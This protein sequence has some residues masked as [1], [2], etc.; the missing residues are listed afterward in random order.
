MGLRRTGLFEAPSN[1]TNVQR[2]ESPIGDT[3]S[4]W[5]ALRQ[6]A[7]AASRALQPLQNQQA[8][9]QAQRDY[10][11]GRVGLRLQLNAEDEVY[12]NAMTQ[13]YLLGAERDVDQRALQLE[14]EYADDADGFTKAFEAARS[15]FMESVPNDLAPHL[16]QLLDT[17][18]NEAVSRIGERRRNAAVASFAAN[19]AA[20]LTQQEMRLT[21]YDDPTSQEFQDAFSAYEETGAAIIANPL[22]GITSEEW[23]L[24]RDNFM[25]RVTA[26]S[27]GLTAERMYEEGGANASAAA[28]AMSFIEGRMRDPELVL[29]EAQRDASFNEARRR[30]MRLETD[31]RRAESEGRTQMRLMR[32]DATIAA[33]DYMSGAQAMAQSF[34]VI[35]PDQI[36]AIGTVVAA[37]GNPTLARE[38]NELQITNHVRSRL[39]GLSLSQ[40]DAE[41]V[42]IRERAQNGD[43]DAAFELRAAS[44]YRQ[45][46]TRADPLTIGQIHFGEEPASIV[47]AD[48]GLSMSARIRDAESIAS[49]LGRSD[50]TYFAPGEAEQL[51]AMV[52]GGGDNAVY[53]AR[54]IVSDSMA[55]GGNGIV[56]AHRM[57]A[58]IA[59]RNSPEFAAIGQVY[60]NGGEVSSNTTLMMGRALEAR[61]QEGYRRAALRPQGVAEGLEAQILNDVLGEQNVRTMSA[62]QRAQIRL[63]ADLFYEG[64][65][66][67]DPSAYDTTRNYEAA[68]RGA[69]SAVLGGV[70]RTIGDAQRPF[71]GVASMDTDASFV[72]PRMRQTYNVENQVIIPNWMR[73]DQFATIYQSLS[74]ADF[75]AAGGG[76]PSGGSLAEWREARLVPTG[77]ALGE[78]FLMDSA[79]ATYAIG[80]GSTRRPY[81]FNLNALRERLAERRPDAAVR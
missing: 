12:N 38:Y 59:G 33:R 78:Y 39:N 2:I 73:R 32:A 81:V 48:G 53:V 60:L 49:R 45:N 22:S 51:S 69:V 21:G 1:V 9:R 68:Y 19:A 50:A 79:G 43:M 56:R 29:S 26:N 28:E 23:S 47:S 25:S 35:P 31:R 76:V 57:L 36:E 66:M 6:T 54:Q 8:E 4:V 64:R 18:E 67:N 30:I 27:V 5:V 7:D 3:S 24:R 62:E 65:A 75:S 71:G 40:V 74:I 80:A 34:I 41:I 52:S 63:A 44:T 70:T 77:R 72:D 58:E 15:G 61:R 55:E 46:L 13:S 10:Q 42:A 17:R 14:G 37:S 20:R 16:S 11:D